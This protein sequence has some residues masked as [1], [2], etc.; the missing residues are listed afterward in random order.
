MNQTIHT[1][2]PAIDDIRA[3]L[4]LREAA[5]LA[6]VPEAKVRKDIETGL[7]SP[8]RSKNPERLLFRWADIYILAAL[9]KSESLTATARKNGVEAFEALVEPSM[10]RRAYDRRDAAKLMNLKCRRDQ[11]GRLFA[12]SGRLALDAYLLVDLERVSREIAPRVA[13]YAEGLGRIEEKEGV[14]GGET[15]FR[16]TRLSVRH[17]GKM[18]DGG[19]PVETIIADY[20]YLRK[21]D[22]EFARLYYLAHPTVG[23][24]SKHEEPE[25]AGTPP[26]R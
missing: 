17:V 23:R 21:D 2:P 10:R 7:L 11:P 9:Y 20:P 18:H 8:L 26:A 25:I 4:S 1:R 5:L 16:D 13:L 24:P 19:E 22:V 15:V 6:D 3:L 12:A 14:L